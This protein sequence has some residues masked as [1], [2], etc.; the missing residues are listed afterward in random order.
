MLATLRYVGKKSFVEGHS[1]PY[2]W[3]KGDN[4]RGARDRA[5]EEE[6]EGS[7]FKK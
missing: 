4:G 2:T 7:S 5:M 3:K 1:K 6:E